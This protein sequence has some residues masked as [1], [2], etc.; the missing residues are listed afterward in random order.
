MKKIFSKKENSKKTNLK[1]GLGE[2]IVLGTKSLY[3]TK[4]YFVFAT[5]LTILILF[6]LSIQY[7]MPASE[8]SVDKAN[9][10]KQ[11]YLSNKAMI[12]EFGTNVDTEIQ[13]LVYPLESTLDDDYL[14][15]VKDDLTWLASK[16]ESVFNLKPANEIY[17]REIA[18]SLLMQKILQINDSF[19]YEF[20]EPDYAKIDL[21][22]N[23]T[24]IIPVILDENELN[25]LFLNENDKQVY[26]NYINQI[27]NEYYSL[28]KT[29]LDNSSSQERKYVEAKKILILSLDEN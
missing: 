9:Y 11:V 23:A 5:I 24:L 16:N 14:Y 2:K 25:E 17:P 10:A 18:Y 15:S 12:E 29:V 3:E 13:N 19:M 8:S 20:G 6:L 26:F 1:N 27:F 22:K 7:Y 28:K 21:A 4:P